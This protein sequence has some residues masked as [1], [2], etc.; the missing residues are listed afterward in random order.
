VTFLSLGT[1]NIRAGWMFANASEQMLVTEAVVK[2]RHQVLRILRDLLPALRPRA[3]PGYQEEEVALATAT[4]MAAEEY[5][6]P[7]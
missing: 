1:R 6:Q 4:I 3:P 2:T 7:P 5:P